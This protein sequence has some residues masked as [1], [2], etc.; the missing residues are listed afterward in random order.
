MPEACP[1]LVLAEV[2]LDGCV[3]V[4]ITHQHGLNAHAGHERELVE[5]AHVLRLTCGDKELSAP[6]ARRERDG[7]GS[8]RDDVLL[9]HQAH[10]LQ[11]H[12]P[13][14]DPDI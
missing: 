11:R 13:F 8:S 5:R 6:L 10:N 1:C 2:A 3:E 9:W 14:T 7:K 4:S 12:G